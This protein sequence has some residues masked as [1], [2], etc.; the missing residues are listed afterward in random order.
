MDGPPLLVSTVGGFCL[1]R[2]EFG[3]EVNLSSVTR[4][5]RSRR[6]HD[7]RVHQELSQAFAGRRKDRVGDRGRNRR[8]S[9]LADSAVCL[10]ARDQMHAD[11][12]SFV[13]AQGPIGAEIGLLDPSVLDRDVS[14]ECRR[15]AENDATFDLG[16]DCGRIYDV[17]VTFHLSISIKRIYPKWNTTWG[18]YVGASSRFGRYSESLFQLNSKET[19]GS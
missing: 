9:V 14:L 4:R 13:D 18:R 15:D 3:C 16:F 11:H 2:P 19:L 17:A 7:S 5:H 10:R 1:R 6:F 12:W 8:R